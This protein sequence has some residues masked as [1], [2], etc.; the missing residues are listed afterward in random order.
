MEMSDRSDGK[1]KRGEMAN[2][3][4]FYLMEKPVR[5]SNQPLLTQTQ[6]RLQNI[7]EYILKTSLR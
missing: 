6:K 1:Y 2:P 4:S 5:E 7:L 3:V